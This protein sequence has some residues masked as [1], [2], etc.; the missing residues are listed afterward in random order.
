MLYGTAI[1]TCARQRIG[2]SESTPSFLSLV[3][4]LNYCYTTICSVYDISE[5]LEAIRINVY[6]L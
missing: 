4:H 6:S 3:S 5:A 2:L 1:R